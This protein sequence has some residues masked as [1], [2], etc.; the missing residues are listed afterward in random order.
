MSVAADGGSLVQ[1]AVNAVRGH[2]RDNHLKVGDTLPGEGHFAAE[3][4]VSR[5]VMREAFG[6]LAA[7]KLLDVANGRRARVGAMDGG[8]IA[9]SLDHAVMTSQI[10]VADVW[11]VRRTVELRIVALAA[12]RRSDAQAERIV[13]LAHA[14]EADAGDM[15]RTI[16][17]DILFHQTIAEA[18]GN[19][20][21]AQIVRSF[22]P[23]MA[24]AVPTAWRTRI[25]ESDRRS[26]IDHHHAVARAI[27]DRNPAA[28][29]AAM[30][31]HFHASIGR[32]LVS[33]DPVATPV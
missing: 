18:A 13:A 10:G 9:A 19:A 4:G 16:E 28:A 7:L 20:L 33:D 32:I 12:E 1:Q 27:A 2:I 26:T 15:A 5:A 25:T 6:A 22:A 14:L 11:E 23:L 8:A 30:E 31:D 21:F 17:H 29:T 24:V 3:L